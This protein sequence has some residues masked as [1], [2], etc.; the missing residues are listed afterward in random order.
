M[1]D[2]VNDKDYEV[3]TVTGK[4]ETL[5]ESGEIWNLKKE[6]EKDNM[7]WHKTI[8]ALR[9]NADHF[10]QQAV[11]LKNPKNQHEFGMRPADMMILSLTLGILSNALEEGTK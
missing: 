1:H 10:R 3:E 8:A 11:I 2:Y 4:K 6:K 9:V 5:N 7:D